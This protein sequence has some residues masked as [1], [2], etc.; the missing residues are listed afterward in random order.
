ML[1]SRVVQDED[2]D[3]PYDVLLFK[4]DVKQGAWGLYNFYKMQ[5]SKV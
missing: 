1:F 5:V 4:I 3:V 2:Q